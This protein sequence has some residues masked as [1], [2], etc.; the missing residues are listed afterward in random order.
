MKGTGRDI[1]GKGIGMGNEVKRVIHSPLRRTHHH[2]NELSVFP[3]SF[4]SILLSIFAS[5]FYV[6]KLPSIS[7]AQV[8]LIIPFPS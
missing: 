1:E 4:P 2:E 5:H 6:F 3:F 7:K 8:Y